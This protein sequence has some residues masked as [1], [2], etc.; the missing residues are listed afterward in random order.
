MEEG[1]GSYTQRRNA[2][3]LTVP[4]PGQ[5]AV[6]EINTALRT[7]S[8]GAKARCFPLSSE[9]MGHSTGLTGQLTWRSAHRPSVLLTRASLPTFISIY[10]H[11][12]IVVL[13][14]LDGL[15][16]RTGDE[17]KVVR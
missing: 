10:L 12:L 6:L 16:L 17:E 13:V 14:G 4:V 8:T 7:L 1:L 15:H 11:T 3:T 2:D 5:S 9:E